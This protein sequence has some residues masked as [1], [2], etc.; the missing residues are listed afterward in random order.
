MFFLR[1]DVETGQPEAVCE[2]CETTF[3]LEHPWDE[4]KLLNALRLHAAEQHDFPRC[5]DPN[6]KATVC[7]LGRGHT[8][9]HR[10]TYVTGGSSSWGP[11]DIY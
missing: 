9:L 10:A 2:Q 6:L 8:G 7:E 5:G 1:F 11:P 4:R 3:D